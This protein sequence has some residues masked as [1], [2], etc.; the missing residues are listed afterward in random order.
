MW[1]ISDRNM[2][3][4]A[5]VINAIVDF[6]EDEEKKK[7]LLQAWNGFKIEVGQGLSILDYVLTKF[8]CFSNAI[9]S[10]SSFLLA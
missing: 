10:L 4:T 7:D 2:E 1:N 9:N 6:L 8:P 3:G 5:G